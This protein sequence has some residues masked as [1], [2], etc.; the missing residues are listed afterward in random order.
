MWGGAGSRRTLFRTS[1]W[2]HEM[3]E[4]HIKEKTF[5]GNTNYIRYMYENS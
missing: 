5:E 2:T 4:V 3:V 1:K